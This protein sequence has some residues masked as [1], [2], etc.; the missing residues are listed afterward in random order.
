DLGPARAVQLRWRQGAAGTPAVAVRE[1]CVWDVAEAGDRLTACYLARV[2]AGAATGF[3]FDLPAELEPVRVAVQALTPG[4]AAA[5]A[6]WTLGAEA[7]GLRPLRVDLAGPADGRLLVTLECVRRGPPTRR[8]VLRFPRPVG[9][10][11]LGGVYGLRAAGVAVEAV[12]RAGV[13]DFAADALFREFGEVRDL[14]LSPAAPPLAFSPQPGAEAELR[15]VLRPGPEPP[16]VTQDVTWRVGP[17]R[18]DGEGAVRWAGKDPVPAV[19]FAVPGARVLEVRGADVAGWGQAD[20]RVQVW[21]RRPTKG[22]EVGWVA[23][24]DPAAGAASADLPA[25]VVADTKGTVATLRVFPA[26]G[27][28]ARAE[29]GRGWRAVPVSVGRGLVF[30]ADGPGLP[31]RVAL[32]PVPA[33]PVPPPRPVERTEVPPP[34]AE[35]VTP[36]AQPVPAVLPSDPPPALPIRTAAGWGSGVL[37]VAVLFLL[38][39]R[40]TWP[41]QVGLLGGLFGMAVAGGPVIGL[42]AWGAARTGWVVSRWWRTVAATG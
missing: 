28:T 33:D 32:S 36:S 21:L 23:A 30:R 40:R 41:E 7:N 13:I 31:V 42:A 8:P 39:P 24:A 2:T 34:P 15:P 14:R 6:G 3:G 10:E 1:G 22:G 18:A 16:A 20:G 27:L 12:E 9:V 11:R 38:L 26:G 37:L 29:P 25:A 17:T 35:A 4:A 19:E 5:I